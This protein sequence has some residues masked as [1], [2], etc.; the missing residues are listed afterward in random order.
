MIPAIRGTHD[1]LPGEIERWQHAEQVIRDVCARY[2]YREI[3][4]PVIERE[5]LFAKGTGET[6]DI[7]QKEMYA[8]E[9]KG[10]ERVTLRPE[11]TP[12]MVR[13]Y[14]EHAL[15]QALP[16]VKLFSFGPM[17]RYERPQKGRYRQFHQL[18]V[19]VFGVSDATLDAEVIEMAASLVRELGVD[20]AELVINS[21]GCRDCRPGFGRALLDALGERKSELCGDCRRRSEMNPLRIFDCKVPSCQPIVD[22]LPHSTDYLCDGC[23]EHFRTV[24][25]QLTALKLE[26][27]VSHR[28]VRGLDY[29][30]RTTFEVLGSTLGAQN[31][32][33]GGGRYDGLVRQLGGPDRA[34]IGFAAGME[35]LVLAMPEGP[36]ASAPDAFVVALGEMAR[37]HAHVLARDLR[38]AGVATLVDY[39]A[40]SLR[41]QMK[42]ANRCGTRW[43]LILGDDEIEHCEVTVKDMEKREQRAIE[44]ANVVQW[45]SARRRHASGRD[46]RPEVDESD[47]DW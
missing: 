4:T 30:A 8:F 19:E 45:L 7:V 26:Y 38:H 47:G 46:M 14:V 39:D 15:E 41:A 1:I 13:A 35:R 5:E 27:R 23:R 2:G 21:V 28:L 6:T 24:T 20:E 40:R 31:A 32:L 34:G 17:F 18:D 11:A 25:D 33:L 10:G 22:A 9:D 44:R 37:A 43:V 29:Y 16:T 36:G 3:R 42:R 12:S